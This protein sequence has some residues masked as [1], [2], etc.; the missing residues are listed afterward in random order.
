[1]H[2]YLEYSCHIDSKQKMRRSAKVFRSLRYLNL[3][4]HFQ[5]YCLLNLFQFMRHNLPMI[6]I[7]TVIYQI[8]LILM[9][10]NYL[11]HLNTFYLYQQLIEY[12]L[13][14]TYQYHSRQSNFHLINLTCSRIYL[15]SNHDLSF[16]HV[17]TFLLQS[18]KHS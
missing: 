8:Y 12:Y 5:Y 2:Q 7:H 4:F 6:M 11:S 17:S 15:Y 3:S 10:Q 13:I 1:M 9:G 14:K 16:L 18:P